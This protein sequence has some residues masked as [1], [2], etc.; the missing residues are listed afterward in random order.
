L[1]LTPNQAEQHTLDVPE[2]P[3][4]P[5]PNEPI[6]RLPWYLAQRLFVRDGVA[7]GLD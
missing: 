5:A 6:I 4:I 2:P 3:T 7:P 1:A